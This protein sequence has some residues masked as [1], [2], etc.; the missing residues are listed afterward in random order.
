MYAYF[1]AWNKI[2][3]ANEKKFVRTQHAMFYGIY[4]KI[5]YENIIKSEYVS[6]YGGDA[7]LSFAN[8]VLNLN[9]QF[10]P[11]LQTNCPI[12]MTDNNLLNHKQAQIC[13][14]CGLEFS[15]VLVDNVEAVDK[16]DD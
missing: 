13:H 3:D 1:E 6:Y 11:L 9:L 15:D 5:D 14:Y 16:D 8:C 12:V 7:A 2:T 10:Y 4:L